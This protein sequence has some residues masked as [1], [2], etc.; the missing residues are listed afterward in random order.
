MTKRQKTIEITKE[1]KDFLGSSIPMV[2]KLN[3]LDSSLCELELL[4]GYRS[5]INIQVT[6]DSISILGFHKKEGRTIDIDIDEE[7]LD[8]ITDL[9]EDQYDKQVK[10]CE[11]LIKQ[12]KK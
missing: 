7:M 1:I 4:K 9:F 12:L 8:K 10:I 3:N 11:D 5:R 6:F 2:D